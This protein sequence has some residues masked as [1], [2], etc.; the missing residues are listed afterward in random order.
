MV[1][2]CVSTG[3]KEVYARVRDA[4]KDDGVPLHDVVVARRPI[5]PLRRVGLHPLEVSHQ[6]SA[7]RGAH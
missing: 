1:G 2:G 6:P 5:H 3:R 7:C 4:P